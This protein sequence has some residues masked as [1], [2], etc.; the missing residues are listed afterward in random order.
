MYNSV[1]L[2]KV[3]SAVGQFSFAVIV[4]GGGILVDFHRSPG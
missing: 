1:H 3:G 2:E 4:R